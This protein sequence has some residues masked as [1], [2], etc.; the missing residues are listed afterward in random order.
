V[1]C[2]TV[3]DPAG[4]AALY[5]QGQPDFSDILGRIRDHFGRI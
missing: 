3:S 5:Y 4:T 1:I 2:T